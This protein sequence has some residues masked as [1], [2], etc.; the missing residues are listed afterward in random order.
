MANE[1]ETRRWLGHIEH[2]QIVAIFLAIYDFVAV[3]VA[4]FLALFLRFHG[5]TIC[6]ITESK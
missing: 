6:G 4:Y 5:Y 2:W 3:C 1:K